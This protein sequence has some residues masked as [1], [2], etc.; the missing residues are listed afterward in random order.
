MDSPAHRHRFALPLL[1]SLPA[2]QAVVPA[3]LLR[4]DA[5]VPAANGQGPTLVVDA[6]GRL[7]GELSRAGSEG[8]N[9]T[10]G[11]NGTT[12]G[13]LAVPLPAVIR[14]DTPLDEALDALARTERRWLPVIDTDGGTPL[15]VIDAGALVRSYR[16]AARTNPRRTMLAELP[17]TT[18]EV[19][20]P[21]ESPMTG[22]ALKEAVL[23]PGVRVVALRRGSSCIVPSGD[24]MLR[25]GD[26][27]Y[28]WS[29]TPGDPLSLI[30]SAG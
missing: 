9:G 24:T 25:A 12:A 5:P 20:L 10:N 27:L 28:V 22:K 21:A 14:A 15:G 30:A 2:G 4:A 18:A 6:D 16:E 23:P 19:E 1:S 17:L 8:T 29:A 26:V 11:T 7:L 13:E 3:T